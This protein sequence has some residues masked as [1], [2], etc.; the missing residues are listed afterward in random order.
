MPPLCLSAG[1][2]FGLGFAATI[3]VADTGVDAEGVVTVWASGDSP[4]TAPMAP[5][6]ITAAPP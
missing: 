1:S 4:T 3:V 2:G 6:V 5:R